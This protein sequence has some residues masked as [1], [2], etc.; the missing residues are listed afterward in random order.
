MPGEFI[1]LTGPSGSGKSSLA[2]DTLHAEGQRRFVESFSP[3]ARQFL[4]RLERPP[5]DALEPIAATVAVDRRAPVKSSRST[6]ATM[7]DLEPY[8]AAL[9]GCEAVPTCPSCGLSAIATSPGQAASRLVVDWEGSRALISYP[10]HTEHS[11]DFLELRENLVRD[12]Y[13]RLFVGGALRDIDTVRPSEVTGTE[14][15]L[16]VVVDRVSIAAGETRR[17]QHAIEVAWERGEG[18]ADMRADRPRAQAPPLQTTLDLGNAAEPVPIVRGLACPK[19]ARGF[20]PP[21]PGLFSYNSPLGACEACRGFGRTIA[22]DW[23]K[24]FPDPDKTLAGGAIRPWTGPSSEWERTVLA[25]FA[26]KNRLPLDVPWGKLT[27]AQ[28]TLVVEG[29]GTW[30]AGKYPGV[31]AWFGW[32]EG[33]TY[34][35]HVRVLLA[36]YREYAPCPSCKTSRL[37]AT[38]LAYQISGKNLATWHELAVSDALAL[39]TSLSPRSP[40]GG[41]V[42]DALVSRLGYLDKVGL[43]YLTLNRQARTLSGGEAQ[44]AGLTTALG[45]SLTSTLFVIDEP[46]VGLHPADVPALGEVMRKLSSAGNTVIAIEHDPGIVR[47]ADRVIELGPGAGKAGGMIVFDGTPAAL[48]ARLDVATGRAWAR[49]CAL[50]YTPR[51]ARDFLVVRGARA[52]NLRDVEVRIPLGVVCALTGPSGSGKSTLA[53]EIVYRSLAR[54]LGDLQVPRPGPHDAIVGASSLARVVLVDQ[55]PLGRTARGNAATYTKAWSRIRTLFAAEPDAK[56]R[57]LSAAHFSF[58]VGESKARAK[59]GAPASGRCE[60]CAGEGYE[61]IEMQFLADVALLCPVCQGKRFRPEIL[62]VT[63]RGQS[64]ADVLSLTVDEALRL[65]DPDDAHDPAVFRMLDPVAQ[66]GLGYLP[67]GQP[68]SMLSGGEAQRLKLAR[69]LSE[70]AK[71]ALFILDEPSAGLHAEDTGHIIRA[72]RALVLGGASV[73]VVEHDLD[74][75]RASD[76]VID[77]G[78]GG[79]PQGGNLVA[80]GTPDEVAQSESKT[81]IALRRYDEPRRANGDVAPRTLPNAPPLAI[82]VVGASEH[83]LKRVS[84]AVPHGKLTVMTGPSGSGKSSLAFDVIFAEGQRRFMETL[85]PYARQFLPTLPRP[86]VDSVTG[87]PPSIALEQRTA[88]AGSNSTVATVTEIAHYLRLLYAKIG[89][90]FCPKC[91]AHVAPTSAEKVYRHIKEGKA[92]GPV[93]LYAPAVRARKGTYLDVFTAAARGGLRAARVDGAIVPID[94]PPKLTKTKEHSIDLIVFYGEPSRLD[95]ATVDLA[96]AWGDGAVRVAHGPPKAKSDDSESVLSTSRACIQCGTGVP[97]LDPRWFSFN[98][99]QGQCEVCEGRGVL[100]GPDSKEGGEAETC[101]ECGG[102]RL[103]RLPRLV[104]LCGATY[105]E[106]LAQ[107]VSTALEQARG[108]S[109]PGDHAVIA[110]AP[111]A[112]LLR[113]LA[114]VER[115]GLGYLALDRHAQTLSGGEMQRLRLSAQLGSGLTGALYVLDEPTIGLHPRD[116]RALLANL[117]ALVDTG[118]TVLVVEHDADVIRGADYVVDLGPGGGREGGHIMASGVAAHVL[119]DPRSPTGRAL[120]ETTPTSRLARPPHLWIEIKGARAHNLKNVTF[121][122]PT[123]RLLVVAGVS[124]SGKSTL[125]RHVFYPALRRALGLVADEPGTHLSIRPSNRGKDIAGMVRAL[126]VDQSPIGRTPRSVPATFLGI[127]NEIR[128]LFA[129]LPEARAR[130]Y[131][132]AR[133]SFNTA[134]GGRCLACEGQGAVVSEMAFLPDVV[135]PCEACGGARFEPATLDIRYAGMSIGDVLRLTAEEAARAFAAHRRIARPLETLCDLGVGYV[136]IGQGSNTL[137]GG[138]AQRLKL[139]AELTAG[140]THEPTVY[141]LDEPTTGLH[142]SDVRRLIE[143]MDRLVVRGDT[144]VVIEHHPEVIQNADWVVEL[145][146]GAGDAGG[147]I[148]FEGPPLEL[149]KAK[150]ATGQYLSGRSGAEPSRIRRKTP[151]RAQ[152]TSGA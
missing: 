25:K 105:A 132:P 3:Y 42:R 126:A 65:F 141:V 147:Q 151:A 59:N 66:V 40:Q 17:L 86:D 7:A 127:W 24:V 48:E 15:R 55:S 16:E 61:T 5:I 109:F 89:E 133:F 46:T 26:K 122:V 32:L 85:T 111:Y 100:G 44:R 87:V 82:S 116:T 114:F 23:D 37:N 43:G 78:P 33:R 41:R 35:M 97:E 31:R 49:S 38:A 36:R 125:V 145:G 106:F 20:D 12:G 115:V 52:N 1:A 152:D 74:V 84:C 80:E 79:G 136:G 110:R 39:A 95:R 13:R 146:P 76:W 148:V 67:L 150:T 11:D 101:T 34:K 90:L 51:K 93:T 28:R 124:G 14:A 120:A 50:P 144:L 53:E 70:P 83:N 142:V 4:E 68:L 69:A 10:V 123:G 21:R 108:F 118:S 19:C 92:R 96:L 119:A 9:F 81:G 138:E 135:S 128:R 77:L 57:G 73:L 129:S 139:A 149:P 102:S 60:A 94:P 98:T 140:S 18:R 112:E 99:K 134:T 104:R 56:R 91:G 27:E 121:R 131:G 62:A 117:R 75:V 130:G 45:A 58:N 88:R 54:S 107:D 71:G 8:L 143:V 63:H 2:L 72:L 137:S 64:V 6:L 113:R 30:H 29:E 22:I 103:A 47:A